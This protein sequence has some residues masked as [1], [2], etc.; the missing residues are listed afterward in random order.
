[1]KM[2][3]KQV[4]KSDWEDKASE[5]QGNP[6]LRYFYLNKFI[7]NTQFLTCL[8]VKELKMVWPESFFELKHKYM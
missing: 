8:W 7:K 2:H 4:I 6:M 5:N 3:L 1:M